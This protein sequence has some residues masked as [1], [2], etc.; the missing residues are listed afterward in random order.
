MRTW[1]PYS[2]LTV[3]LAVVWLLLNQTL[4]PAH[5]LLGVWIAVAAGLRYAA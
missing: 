4:A 3:S 5:G 1:L 2:L